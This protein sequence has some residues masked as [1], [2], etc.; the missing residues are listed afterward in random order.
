MV[1]LL[2]VKPDDIVLRH[3]E[4][5]GALDD[6]IIQDMRPVFDFQEGLVLTFRAG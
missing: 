1:D 4:L 5:H 2:L 3:I 6:V